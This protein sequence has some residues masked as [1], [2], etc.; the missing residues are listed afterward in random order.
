M[1]EFRIELIKLYNLSEPKE[2]ISDG[3]GGKEELGGS[4]ALKSMDTGC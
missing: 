2:S 3:Q 1:Q 4:A